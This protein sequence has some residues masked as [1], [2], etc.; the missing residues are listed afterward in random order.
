LALL[1]VLLTAAR[2]LDA[3][4]VVS[5]DAGQRFRVCVLRGRTVAATLDWSAAK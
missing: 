5:E 4:F 1:P 3:A 2:I